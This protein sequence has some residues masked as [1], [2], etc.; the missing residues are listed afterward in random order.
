MC[1]TFFKKSVLVLL[2]IIYV[3]VI[4]MEDTEEK[5]EKYIKLFIT[6]KE[7][8]ERTQKLMKVLNT[9]QLGKL[10]V[11]NQKSPRKKLNPKKLWKKAKH[12]ILQ[13]ADPNATTITF[14]NTVLILASEHGKEE[15]VRLALNNGAE[16][17]RQNKEGTTALLR[18]TLCNHKEIIK[19]L[20]QHHANVTLENNA[21]NSPL[22]EAEKS[23]DQE[24]K[25]LLKPHAVV[26]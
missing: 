6:Q 4:A 13:G 2:S 21:G 15:L 22:K 9:I 20:L 1:I 17:N 24:I 11:Y 25:E 10:T 23:S 26:W 8:N 19:L 3:P 18:A 16:V 7:L 12:Q 14:N 5:K